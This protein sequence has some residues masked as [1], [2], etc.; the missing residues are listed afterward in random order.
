MVLALVMISHELTFTWHKE[1]L[2]DDVIHVWQVLAREVHPNVFLSVDWIRAWAES[3]KAISWQLVVYWNN[4]LIG[5]ALWREQEHKRP[6]GFNVTTLHLNHT[7]E[8]QKDQIWPEYN[9][10]L[11][12][13]E[14]EHTVLS[15]LIDNIFDTHC[16]VNEIDTGLC[17]N[18]KLEQWTADRYV[19]DCWLKSQ[20]YIFDKDISEW[21]SS[22]SK[23]LKSEINRT[24][25][26]LVELG[27]GE[28]EFE[29]LP[30][31]CLKMLDEMAELH[32][33]AW[34]SSS[35]FLNS[36][37]MRFHHYLIK[38]SDYD[39]K[40]MIVNLVSPSGLL[41]RHYLLI[42]HETAYFY[43]GVTKKNVGSR[44]KLGTYLHA[45]TIEQLETLGCNKYDFLGGDYRY[46]SR[47][48][49][50]NYE[51]SRILFKRATVSFKVERLLKNLKFKIE[52]LLAHDA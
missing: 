1:P 47:M 2:I 40:P 34:G 36:E 35:G 12:L 22:F 28:I 32:E 30:D 52:R 31:K 13:P 5:C 4:K 50:T 7:G 23:N 16:H 21:Q 41:C 10:I 38:N 46:K 26:G 11:C 18:S 25:R 51:M 33:Q 19:K 15:V 42:S 45:K 20:T 17:L 29:T 49:N 3:Y 8:E 6:L 14:Y 44:I 37:F 9:G 24:Q 48:A 27:L 39:L 43:L